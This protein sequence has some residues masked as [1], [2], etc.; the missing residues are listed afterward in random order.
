[1]KNRGSNR[2]FQA[3]RALFNWNCKAK[4]RVKD[5]GSIQVRQSYRCIPR[6]AC[7]P[8]DPKTQGP[9]LNLKGNME[10]PFAETR[11]P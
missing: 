6:E 1:V 11:R 3:N 4:E 5:E 9:G 7:R 8:E 10:N 2:K